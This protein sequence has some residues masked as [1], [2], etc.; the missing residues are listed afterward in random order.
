M[1]RSARPA[2]VDVRRLAEA[3]AWRARLTETGAESSAG[4]EAWLAADP[5][6]ADA[7]AAVQAPWIAVGEAATSPEI[8]A[9]RRD[10]LHRARRH[11]RRRWSGAGVYTRICAGALAAAACVAIYV[12]AT[13][14]FTLAEDYRTKVGDRETVTLKDGSRITLDS[15]SEVRVRY[16]A[17]ARRL[18]LLAGQARFD[19]AHDTRRPFTVQARDETVVATGTAFNVDLM[20]PKVLVTLIQGRVTVLTARPAKTLLAAG[21]NIPPPA[22]A[23]PPVVLVAGQQLIAG[24]AAAP[25]VAP[26]SLDRVGAWESGQLIFDDETLA[27]VAER[28]SRYTAHPLTVDPSAASMKISGVFNTGDLATFVDTVTHYLPVEASDGADGSVVLRRKG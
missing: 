14:G 20:G 3:S 15:G 22:A 10:A 4:F 26:A 28:M 5:A 2:E 23:P 6:N 17:K 21:T 16:S 12:A 7:W 25:T 27:S 18:V 11:G 9:A 19:V 13:G 24:P 8:M 1:T